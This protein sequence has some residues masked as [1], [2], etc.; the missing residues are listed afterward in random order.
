MITKAENILSP[1]STNNKKT[2]ILKWFDCRHK[3]IQT[4]A[5]EIKVVSWNWNWNWSRSRS[6]I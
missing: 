5:I 4:I 3:Q 2:F 6:R 1:C